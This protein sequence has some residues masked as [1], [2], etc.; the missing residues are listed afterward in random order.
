MGLTKSYFSVPLLHSPHSADPPVS[1]IQRTLCSHPFASLS[2][3]CSLPGMSQ[4]RPKNIYSTPAP[5]G[6]SGTGEGICLMNKSHKIEF[7]SLPASL[8]LFLSLLS[9]SLPWPGLI[10]MG[11]TMTCSSPH[12]SANFSCTDTVNDKG[13]W[14]LINTSKSEKQVGQERYYYL[15][16]NNHSY[17]LKNPK[18]LSESSWK[19]KQ[20]AQ[21]HRALRA[22]SFS[23]LNLSCHHRSPRH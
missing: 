2:L 20:L 11:R 15:H 13:H 3:R 22:A 18:E 14:C 19:M 4:V 8:P 17:I 9:P 16:F 12:L 7:L 6:V 23:D 1:Q 5:G 10:S 21:P